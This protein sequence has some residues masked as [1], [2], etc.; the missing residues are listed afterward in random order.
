MGS[1]GWNMNW[2]GF[3][4]GLVGYQ[5]V[6]GYSV[7]AGFPNEDPPL[8]D[9]EEDQMGAMGDSLVTLRPDP[10]PDEHNIPPERAI[11]G[12][13]LYDGVQYP[14]TESSRHPSHLS[15]TT[16]QTS[17]DDL[18]RN[19]SLY[20]IE[21]SHGTQ[22]GFNAHDLDHV[23]GW[24]QTDP[25]ITDDIDLS[26][27][28]GAQVAQPPAVKVDAQPPSQGVHPGMM[29]LPDR[30]NQPLTPKQ[31]I[32][33]HLSHVNTHYQKRFSP[34]EV[35]LPLED[36]T[37]TRESLSHLLTD[38][39]SLIQTRQSMMPKYPAT[40]TP[41]SVDRGPQMYQCIQCLREGNV[42]YKLFDNPGSFRRHVTEQHYPQF[43]Y[44][45]PVD[46]CS[47]IRFRRSKI[48]N[49][50]TNTHKQIPC[51]KVIDANTH[52]R[53][54]ELVCKLCPRAVKNWKEFYACFLSH[55]LISSPTHS[56]RSSD[57]RGSAMGG[58]G[59]DN[60]VA[61]SSTQSSANPPSSPAP[62]PYSRHGNNVDEH[63]SNS[64]SGATSGQGYHL[65]VPVPMS[66]SVSD[67]VARRP[68][69]TNSSPSR[70]SRNLNRRIISGDCLPGAHMG[71]CHS[72][73]PRSSLRNP[74][75]QS[76]GPPELNCR[77]CGRPFDAC[78]ICRVQKRSGGR[79]C[80]CHSSST[81]VQANQFGPAQ[82]QTIRYINPEMGTSGQGVQNQPI[83]QTLGTPPSNR[84]QRAP[85]P[86][87]AQFQGDFARQMAR[88][89]GTQWTTPG[90]DYDVLTVTE[91]PE[92]LF[93]KADLEYSTCTCVASQK[94]LFPV[95]A[96]GTSP[97]SQ[98]NYH[99]RS[100]VK[101]QEAYSGHACAEIAPG[102]Q[103][104][105]DLKILSS[106]NRGGC[107]HSSHLRTRVQLVVKLLKL[108]SSAAESSSRRHT[109]GATQ[110]LE[111]A[112]EPAFKRPEQRTAA[113]EADDS[114]ESDTESVFDDDA[115]SMSSSCSDIDALAPATSDLTCLE[116]ACC[117]EIEPSYEET[118][119]LSFDFDLD[120]AL[121]VL[122][123]WSGGLSEDLCSD[124]A[125]TDPGS[126][127]EYFFKYIMWVIVILARSHE[128]SR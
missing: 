14:V 12:H 21:P 17:W 93:D 100:A 54:V 70:L 40:S 9:A 3:G 23:A 72:Q 38:V 80:K 7:A 24:N 15:G 89:M 6:A 30:G 79:C 53:P 35:V 123:R 29:G 107:L 10:E 87:A 32:Q 90:G 58:N 71:P 46:R 34:T 112:L 106:E 109:R 22:Q 86:M 111:Q 108:R 57:D 2:Q 119:A 99:R 75:R 48:K 101:L 122:S 97:P 42:A 78:G 94:S 103:M 76:S 55:C 19:P 83:E 124:L 91:V 8:T 16:S 110:M 1:G 118:T 51:E 116:D 69:S 74:A 31:T 60:N 47:E 50:L 114:D 125:V 43:E 113:E 121:Y 88:H 59:T 44:H 26:D 95:P 96:Q 128:Y 67:T 105:L 120:S 37:Q 5:N 98:C 25:M 18:F 68:A 102:K 126:I 11:P 77:G 92:P 27:A 81:A 52:E 39:D 13:M 63:Q 41:P 82:G 84:A 127:L 73:L 62:P 4:Q 33:D 65:A 61:S 115:A 49:H 104:K 64:F 85:Q 20:D 28:A 45:C 36:L 56:R 66:R 117:V